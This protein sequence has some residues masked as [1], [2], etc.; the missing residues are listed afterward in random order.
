MAHPITQ[1]YMDKFL[2]DI[3]HEISSLKADFKSCMLDF[4]RDITAHGRTT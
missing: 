1:D 2:N 3:K 4:C